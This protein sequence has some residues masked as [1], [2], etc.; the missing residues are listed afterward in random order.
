MSLEDR[1][2]FAIDF[3]SVHFLECRSQII[4][5]IEADLTA[6]LTN[7]LMRISVGDLATLTKDVLQLAPAAPG[8]QVVNSQTVSGSVWSVT[9]TAA[10]TSPRSR[11]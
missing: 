8:R 10:T 5:T 2:L 6:S 1:D 11:A 3:E 7:T 4:R 9:T